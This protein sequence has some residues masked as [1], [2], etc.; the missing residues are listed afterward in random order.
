LVPALLIPSARAAS[1]GI[2]QPW[3]FFWLSGGLSSFLDNTPTYLAFLSMAQG[4]GL[5]GPIL[6]IPTMLLKA[7]SLGAVFMGANTYIG[8]G[9]NFMVKLIAEEYK[10]KMPSFFGYMAYSM[11]ILVPLYLV[12]TLI[13][14][15]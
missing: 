9:P 4:L 7:I 11:A 10:Y 3:Q 5:N 14:F 2:T 12:I 15:R 1:P 6:G 13:F 8:N